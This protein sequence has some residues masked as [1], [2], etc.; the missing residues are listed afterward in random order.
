LTRQRAARTHKPGTFAALAPLA[1]IVVAASASASQRLDCRLGDPN[2]N[3]VACGSRKKAGEHCAA[4]ARDYHPITAGYEPGST[5]EYLIRF[6][7][8]GMIGCDPAGVRTVTYFQELRNSSAGPFVRSGKSTTK[9]TNA[10]FLLR[11]TQAIPLNCSV[12]EPGSA[13]RTLVRLSWHPFKGWGG[14][15]RPPVEVAST[16]TPICTSA[17]EKS[18]SALREIRRSNASLIREA[19]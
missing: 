19:I 16:P 10:G 15:G 12:D 14:G 2:Y 4:A 13:V 6:Q 8:E 7:V 18:I 17:P 5:S 11:D 1:V 9:A 3:T